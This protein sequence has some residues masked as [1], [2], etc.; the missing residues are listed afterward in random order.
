MKIFKVLG[1]AAATAVLAAALSVSALA[2]G[3]VTV[4]GSGKVT[5]SPDTAIISVG[6][7]NE[8]T[9]AESVAKENAEKMAKVVAAA[10]SAGVAEEK[11]K[12]SRLS[13]NPKYSYEKNTSRIVGY[14][15][16]NQITLTVADIEKAG[17]ILDAAFKAGANYGGGIT[18]TL[19]DRDKYYQQAL[20]AAVT[21]AKA[22]ADTIAKAAGVK[23]LA[24]SEITESGG[25]NSYS[26]IYYNDA[27]ESANGMMKAASDSVTTPVSAGE[28]EV[29]ATVS[30]V[31]VY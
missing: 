18:F 9:D 11:I 7:R 30:I 13:L 28:I 24:P 19:S 1:S 12:T 15:A 10:K 26:P 14:N 6:V 2:D 21:N 31:Y 3:R 20:T 22:K 17:V 4:T 8:G 16:S 27:M 23:T 25:Y 5:V 29:S